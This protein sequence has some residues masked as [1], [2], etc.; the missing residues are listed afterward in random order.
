MPYMIS[1]VVELTGVKARTIREYIQLGMVPRPE[2][3]GPAALYDEAHVLR[4]RTIAAMRARGA[5]RDEI[6]ATIR[7]WSNAKL[8]RWLAQNEPEAEQADGGPLPDGRGTDNGAALGTTASTSAIASPAA[9]APALASASTSASASASTSASTSADAVVDAEP[10]PHLPPP[11][12][13]ASNAPLTT[14]ALPD[15]PRWRVLPLLPRLALVLG[16]DATPLAR[17]IAEEIYEKYAAG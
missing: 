8:K 2:G 12:A 4:I 5:L 14:G 9:S 13:A 11:R 10:V 3:N 16:D 17:R 7:G 15:V 1:H 6:A